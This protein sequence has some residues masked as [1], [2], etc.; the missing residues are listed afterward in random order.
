MVLAQNEWTQM[1]ASNSRECRNCHNFGA[2]QATKQRPK[3]QAAH[4]K[5]Q[6]EGATCID[7]HK[8]IAH[9]LPREFQQYDE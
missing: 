9:R 3:A 7:C 4:A 5:A 2:M 6:E 1:K 8:G